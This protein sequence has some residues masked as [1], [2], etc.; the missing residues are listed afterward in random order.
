MFSWVGVKVFH[1]IVT[2]S[3]QQMMVVVLSKIVLD[4]ETSDPSFVLPV[5]STECSIWLEGCQ[6]SKGLSLTLDA[7]FFFSDCQHKISKP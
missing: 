5:D 1:Y 2:F 4:L 7:L 3:F 6:L